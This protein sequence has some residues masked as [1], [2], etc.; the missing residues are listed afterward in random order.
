[1]NMLTQLSDLVQYC[2]TEKVPFTEFEDWTTITS[3]V[4]DIVDGK[5]DVKSVAKLGRAEAQAG[6]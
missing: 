1:M 4:K 6:K 2:I 3:T 5:T